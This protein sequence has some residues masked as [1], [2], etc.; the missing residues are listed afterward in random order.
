MPMCNLAPPRTMRALGW[1]LCVL[2]ALLIS[3]APRA[4]LEEGKNFS[5]VVP[6]QATSQRNKIEVVE[7]FSYGC[8]HCARFYPLLSAWL[9]QLPP[10]VLFRRVP[11]GFGR[12]AWMNL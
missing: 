9:T 2:T 8:P 12:D 7:F 11:V 6:P 3:P 1:A 10:D 5:T 4:A